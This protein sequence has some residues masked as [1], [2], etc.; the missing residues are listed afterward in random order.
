[1]GKVIK[2]GDK[3]YTFKEELKTVDF[4]NGLD[5]NK[6]MMFETQ[7]GLMASASQEPN[8]LSKKNVLLM[9]Y[10]EFLI[11]LKKFNEIYGLSGEYDFLEA[12]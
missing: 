4:L 11:L 9:P 7:I 10:A 1:M 8:K 3:E 2:I 6:R 12:K 5:A